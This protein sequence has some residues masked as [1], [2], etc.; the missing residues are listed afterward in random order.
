[1][2][3]GTVT[4]CICLARAAVHVLGAAVRIF[5]VFPW[6]TA[7]QQRAQIQHW[8]AKALV[9][10]GLRVAPARSGVRIE[11]RPCLYIANHVSWLDVIAIWAMTDT[12]FVAK[13]EVAHW[14]VFGRL[15]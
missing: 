5:L 15:A 3:T 9:I 8:S 2:V 11:T 12:L 10:F 1:M 7:P 14:P 4:R 6:L 13:S